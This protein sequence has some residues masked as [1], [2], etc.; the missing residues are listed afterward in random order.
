MADP[1]CHK[2]FR[3]MIGKSNCEATNF[4]PLYTKR[5]NLVILSQFWWSAAFFGNHWK[6]HSRV[7][8]RISFLKGQIVSRS[9]AVPFWPL[10]GSFVSRKCNILKL[11][12]VLVSVL[13]S[14][15]AQINVI[16]IC[17]SNRP[18]EMGQLTLF[19]HCAN[20][21]VMLK[22]VEGRA[23]KKQLTG[24]SRVG[25]VGPCFLTS[26]RTPALFSQFFYSP[27]WR[28]WSDTHFS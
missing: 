28:S 4:G 12:C 2:T 13:I 21:P 23:S 15:F 11:T 8:K 18:I 16:S 5:R 25:L 14:A 22:L 1:L 17:N 6:I 27:D 20:E 7:L 24:L 3:H 26:R 10:L 19:L 9:L